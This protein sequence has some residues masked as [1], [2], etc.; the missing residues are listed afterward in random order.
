MNSYHHCYYV[1]TF[2]H[3]ESGKQSCSSLNLYWCTLSCTRK[4]CL[5]FSCVLAAPLS[6]GSSRCWGSW[7]AVSGI[8]WIH[9]STWMQASLQ[10]KANKS[11]GCLYWT[12]W[13]LPLVLPGSL[14]ET[15]FCK[16]IIVGASLSDNIVAFGKTNVLETLTYKVEQC[17]TVFHEHNEVLGLKSCLIWRDMSGS[18]G[19]HAVYQ[20][21]GISKEHKSL[22]S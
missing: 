14:F 10:H 6:D 2:W 22:I 3:S 16:V 12:P 1:I 18:P 21:Y 7:I 9:V 4:I 20:A 8:A 11:V 5:L 13:W 15:C 17:R 19:G